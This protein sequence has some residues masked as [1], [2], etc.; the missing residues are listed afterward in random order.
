MQLQSILL[1]KIFF[2]QRFG[3]VFAYVKLGRIDL[4]KVQSNVHKDILKDV[5]ISAWNVRD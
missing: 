5:Q 1:G 2:Q 3:P 4:W